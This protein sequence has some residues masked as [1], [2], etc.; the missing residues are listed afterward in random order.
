MNQINNITNY[1]D[2]DYVTDDFVSKTYSE[3]I[4]T[5]LV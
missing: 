2:V 3:N 4:Q 1:C 5:L